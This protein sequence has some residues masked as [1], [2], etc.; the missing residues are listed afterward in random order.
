MNRIAA[1]A[2]AL[3]LPVFAHAAIFTVNDA[4][5]AGDA[6][7]GNGVCA[8]AGGVCT[9]R[10]ALQEANALAGTDTINFGIGSGPQTITPASPLPVASSVV[11]DGTTQLGSGAGPF[12]L[13]DGQN[14]T[15]IGL[16]IPNAVNS[17]NV[18]VQGL[19]IGRF[20]EAGIKTYQVGTNVTVK[21]CNIGVGL[22]GMTV[23]QNGDGILARINNFGGSSL[24]VG[25][26]TGG[27]N[28]I[29]GNG[30]MGIEIVDTGI[31]AKLGTL[32]LQGNKI[33]LGSDGMTAVP[34][35]AS[36]IRVNIQFGTITVG[37]SPAGRN[38]ISGNIGGGFITQAF[39]QADLIDF[40]HNYVGLAQDGVTARGNGS[41]GASLV[42]RQYDVTSNVIG[43]NGGH[44][45]IVNTCNLPSTIRGNRIGVAVDGSAQ[46]NAGQGIR[47][48]SGSP[49]VVG[50]PGA[51]QNVIANNG[52]NGI[53]LIS[54][55][56]AEIAENTIH[57]NGGLGID[58]GDNG[59][60]ANDAGDTDTVGG[61]NTQNHPTIGSAVHSGG[62]TFVSGSLSSATSTTYTLRFFSSSAADPSGYGEGET[63]LGAM[64][65]TTN[66]AGSA[67]FTF[68]CPALPGTFITATATNTSTG[69]TSEFSNALVVSGLPQFRMAAPTV[70]TPESGNVTLTIERINGS[71]GAAS[72]NWS[73]IP[74][75]AGTTDFA[76]ASGTANF[77]SGETAK[78]IAIAIT[79]DALD[80]AL[81]SF[82]VELSSPS[83]GTQL[84]SPVRTTVDI[85]D[86][87][88]TPSLSIAG[89][90]GGEAS[91]PLT[92]N[93][94]LS[95][96]SGR[97]ITVDYLTSNGSA[98]AG[99]DYAATAGTLTF[100]P[101]AALQTIAIPIVD[102]ASIELSESFTV[103]L[104]NPTNATLAVDSAAATISDDDGPPSITIDDV[105]V[106][107]GEPAALTV[108]LSGPS[109]STVTVGWST[110][111]GTAIAGDDYSSGSGTLSFPPGELEQIIVVTVDEDA[112]VENGETFFVDLAGPVNATLA[113]AQGGGTIADD[114]GT[115]SL[116]INDPAVVEG[117]NATFTVTLAPPSALPVTV[118]YATSDGTA[119]SANDYTGATNT[120]T[121]AAG[122]TS[123]MI[124]VATSADA[125][126]ESSEQFALT[127]SSPSGATIAD[128]D[129]TGTIIDD[130]G[131]PRVTIGNVSLPEGN[132]GGTTFTFTVDLSHASASAIDVTWS[133]ADGTADALDYA[134]AGGTLTF[135]PGETS[136]TLDVAVST[137][138]LIE[139][140]ETF[141]VRLTGAT[142]ATITD[143]EGVGTI[144]N[145]D[146]AAEVSIVDDSDLEGNTLT[147]T[148]VL[149][150][151]TSE[152]VTVQW[153]TANGT[154]SAGNDYPGASGSVVIAPGDL[155][156]TISV[157]TTGDSTFE[158]DETF[159]INLLG[160][161]NATITDAQ[162]VGVILNEDPAPAVP[163]VSVDSDGVFETDAGTTALTLTVSLSVPTVNTVTVQ[164][165]TGG[166]SATAG[167]DYVGASGTLTFAPGVTSQD[168]TIAVI[169]DTLVEGDETFTVTLSAPTNA[170]LGTATGTGTILEDDVA[171]AVPAI[172][173]ANASDAEGDVGSTPLT[174]AVTLSVPTIATVTVDYATAA[175]TATASADYATT[176]GTL[177]FAPGVTS[178]M[179]VVPIVGDTSVESNETFTVTLASPANA[180]LG[181]ASATGTI[182]D[183][184]ALP[185]VPAITIGDVVLNEGDS[186]ATLFAFPVT[187]S[188]ATTLPVSVAWTTSG[189]AADIVAAN[190]TLVFAPGMTAQ[191]IHVA[192][193][194]DEDLESDDT[195]TVQLSAPS[196][197][198]LGDA[199]GTGTIRNDDA[200]SPATPAL[201]AS[202]ASVVE[203]H[204]GT[205]E[206]HVPLTLSSRATAGASV[207]WMTRGATAVGGTDFTEASGRVTF[208]GS[209]TTG[210]IAL[211]VVGDRVREDSETFI[212]ELFDAEGALLADPRVEVTIA[213]DDGDMPL[214][215]IV[216]AV[217]SVRGNAGSRFG[218]AVQMVNFSDEPAVGMLVFVPAGTQGASTSTP[219]S[220]APREM[221]VFEDLLPELGLGG[222][223][224]LD[225]I[226]TAGP[227]PR[228]S[229][230]IYDDGS[231]TGTTGFTLPVVAPEDALSAGDGGL[232]F[233]P[234][235][236]GAMRFN[237]GIRTLHDGASIAIEVRDRTGA[238][239]HTTGR[240]LPAMWFSQMSG[241]E[242]AGI[243][244][245]GGDYIAVRVTRGS[246]I[247]YGAAVDNVTNDPSV[248]LVTK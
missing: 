211:S 225:V 149:S 180:T 184:D 233:P 150:N 237:V 194:G 22:D 242:L 4:G 112:I 197:A 31:G 65:V 19:A 6:S 221:R 55:G 152:P 60:S 210:T 40:S 25:D 44:G 12:I 16:E 24:I 64:S 2:L 235:D 111:D 126:A 81:E 135:S 232:L 37:G 122:E 90:A 173:I 120:L 42:A 14:A 192:V 175:G 57:A 247:L 13:L 125:T 241:D 8:T 176:N 219:Y 217:G 108:R 153:A 193:H 27:G 224:T 80:E 203:G 95:A 52:G 106:V 131:A 215:G 216:L 102:D 86:D 133:T 118:T 115:P 163:A 97:I 147:F 92:L 226:A 76:P 113:D 162:G 223:A 214:R 82:E 109:A 70:T 220:L 137:D 187:L 33:G 21:R 178:Q 121:F 100:A 58:L 143:S 98:V 7:A 77:A 189:G 63:Y 174:F 53:V 202:A 67:S 123:R 101:G 158:A 132:S 179:I 96:P 85:T 164:F 191:T 51:D 69:D 50:G 128:A 62:I 74:G 23:M 157:A 94:T 206:V 1:L 142:N 198:T 148:V 45:L 169:G 72:V 181:T 201:R 136:R 107:E 130:D 182:L 89:A 73:T 177:T 28:V 3:V 145:D 61:N 43:A 116:S 230:R 155:M 234:D 134:A 26:E 190:G 129:G 236:P 207:R 41:I 166:G 245:R 222:L 204:D 59:V 168:V 119:T 20:T 127:L 228:M 49:F 83:V 185:A 139:P 38:L 183:D 103:M 156:E 159:F 117:V 68:N 208:S 114:D 243:T 218:T 79:P 231:G 244:L 54:S 48:V 213:D 212:V 15:T 99:S 248:H 240:E 144:G 227:L 138:L 88:P 32:T 165:A 199:N 238:T 170:T 205:T 200:R 47:I 36:G 124:D 171:P 30:D 5:D 196:N 87:D 11:I 172:S 66:A 9:L 56:Q 186:G 167:S 46:G 17:L 151:G 209:A 110:S 146:G 34:N 160:A 84:G 75:S 140:D 91:T 18:T 188:V 35:L 246:A 229:V 29:S 195:F 78:M 71:S 141:L 154:A 104:S 161:T 93:V 10:A 239:L 105:A 39:F